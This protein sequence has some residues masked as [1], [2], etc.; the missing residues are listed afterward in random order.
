LLL[1]T[2]NEVPTEFPAVVLWKFRVAS[3]GAQLIMWGTL[4]IAFGASVERVF[5]TRSLRV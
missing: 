5:A 1:P 3:M 4:G 2:I